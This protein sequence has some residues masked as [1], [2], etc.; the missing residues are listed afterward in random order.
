MAHIRFESV[1]VVMKTN[2]SSFR[3]QGKRID[4]KKG[5]AKVTICSGYHYN[6]REEAE[7][8][9]ELFKLYNGPPQKDFP[10][11]SKIDW[12]TEKPT[13][14]DWDNIR[15]A[16]V[17]S[18]VDFTNNISTK[19]SKKRDLDISS[20]RSNK[21]LILDEPAAPIFGGIMLERKSDRKYITNYKDMSD[22]TQ[23]ELK[24]EVKLLFNKVFNEITKNQENDAMKKVLLD[25]FAVKDDKLTA[26][27]K[28]TVKDAHEKKDTSLVLQLLSLAHEN[29]K[30][31]EMEDFFGITIS[32]RFFTSIRWHLEV[33]GRGAK[34]PDKL[35]NVHNNIRRRDLISLFVKYLMKVCIKSAEVT[36]RKKTSG[37]IQSGPKFY[38]KES[39]NELISAFRQERIEFMELTQR[40][41]GE[42]RSGKREYVALKSES[43]IE[44]VGIFCPQI[45]TNLAALDTA[46][47]IHI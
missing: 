30:R 40:D 4:T 28:L 39:K 25:M 42:V 31:K 2:K 18:D 38:R 36:N 14:I 29:M 22:R 7:I 26:S 35:A 33:H 24:N 32:G 34:V 47:G 41:R 44:I 12:K 13:G 45:L 21:R 11:P 6:T 46:S 15:E 20:K 43:M 17:K 3:L 10:I 16:I 9:V 5:K 27:Y 23:R 8:D 1:Y 37:E 19:K